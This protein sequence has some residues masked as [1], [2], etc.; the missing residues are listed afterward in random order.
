MQLV[1]LHPSRGIISSSLLRR[2]Y[3]G[4]F[5]VCNLTHQAKALAAPLASPTLTAHLELH[6][7]LSSALLSGP[8][9]HL[10]PPTHPKTSD[11]DHSLSHIASLLTTVSLLRS[12]PLQAAKRQLALPHDI[13]EKHGVVEESV[14]REGSTAHGFRDACFEIGTRGMDELITARSHTKDDGGKIEPKGVM[15]LFLSAVRYELPRCALTPQ[16]PAESYLHRLEAVD[17]DVFSPELQKADWKLAPNIW[18]AAQ[19]CKL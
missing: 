8:L 1:K 15:P 4:L 12:L 3:V 19:T 17:F 18:W 6:G 2:G 16:I 14:L 9:P 13:R 5:S 11:V 7:P 10:L